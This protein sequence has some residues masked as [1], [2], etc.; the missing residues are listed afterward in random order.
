MEYALPS[1]WGQGSRGFWTKRKKSATSLLAVMAMIAGIAIAFKLFERAIPNN[2]VR[3]ASAFN[4][5]IHVKRTAANCSDTVPNDSGWCVASGVDPIYRAGVDSFPGDE[6]LE[7]V[8]IRNTNK[9]PAKDASFEMWVNQATI[10]INGCEPV[11]ADGTCG[12][13]PVIAST[14]PRYNKFLGFWRLSVDK[15]TIVGALSDP[16]EYNTPLFAAACEGGLKELTRQSPC[17]LGM[18]RSSGTTSTTPP[19]HRLD[20]RLY[21]F[22]MTEEDTGLDQSE[23]KGWTVTFEL[24]FAARV[25]A[26]A[27][28]GGPVYQ[29]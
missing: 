15:E 29:R 24:D 5:E 12:T 11:A 14:D 19:G 4:Y 22:T 26:E 20:Q 1:A 18:I 17:K 21:D 10:V 9:A 3:D 6:R 28:S 23:Y 27:E 2:V 25:P 8:R 7:E 16:T 13:T